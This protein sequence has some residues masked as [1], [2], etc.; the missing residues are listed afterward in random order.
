MGLRKWLNSLVEDEFPEN[1]L[2]Y[3]TQVARRNVEKYTSMDRTVIVVEDDEITRKILSASILKMGFECRCFSDSTKAYKFLSDL[4]KDLPYL[5]ISDLMMEDGDGVDLLAQ[6][7]ED[8]HLCNI[9]FVFLT[10]ANKDLFSGILEN[11]KYDGFLNKPINSKDLSL[12]L[13]RFSEKAA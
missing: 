12:L 4:K 3:D 1:A 2:E 5:I 6:V 11:Y 13:T 10:G 7:R 8:S 9:P